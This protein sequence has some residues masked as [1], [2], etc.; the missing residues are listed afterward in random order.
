MFVHFSGAVFTISS[1]TARARAPYLLK[2]NGTGRR[3]AATISILTIVNVAEIL[4]RTD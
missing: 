3:R 1:S 2:P 4:S